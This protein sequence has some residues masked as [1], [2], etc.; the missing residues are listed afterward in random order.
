MKIFYDK[1]STFNLNIHDESVASLSLR[2]LLEIYIYPRVDRG[3]TVSSL[4]KRNLSVG[5]NLRKPSVTA[6]CFRRKVLFDMY[7]IQR[8]ATLKWLRAQQ[9]C[10]STTFNV[11]LCNTRVTRCTSQ[12]ADFVASQAAMLDLLAAENMFA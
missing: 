11:A 1:N 7:A 10:G 3:F 8:P 6:C 2:Y 9:S 12:S 5:Y 4:P